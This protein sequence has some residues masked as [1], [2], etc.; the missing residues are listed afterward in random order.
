MPYSALVGDQVKLE[1]AVILYSEERLEMVAN[2]MNT[3]HLYGL[4]ITAGCVLAFRLLVW[5][6]GLLIILRGSK[7]TERPDILRTYALGNPLS[8]MTSRSKSSDAGQ[9]R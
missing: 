9:L 4:A 5:L 8:Q 7:P 3:A 2:W 1:L 6:A